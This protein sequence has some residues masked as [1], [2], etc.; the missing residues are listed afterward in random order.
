MSTIHKN[1]KIP[2]IFVGN[3]TKYDVNQMRFASVS[4]LTA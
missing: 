1:N 4:G 3:V 2:H